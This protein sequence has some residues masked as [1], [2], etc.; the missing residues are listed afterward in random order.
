[1]KFLAE[2]QDECSKCGGIEMSRRAE[3]Q[4]RDGYIKVKYR[5]LS[6]GIKGID[7]YDAH[8]G[9]HN[10]PNCKTEGCGS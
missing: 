9:C 4:D 2:E 5:C 3:K 7:K 1:M 6:C 8:L 10:W